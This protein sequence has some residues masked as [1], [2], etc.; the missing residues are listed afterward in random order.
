MDFVRNLE[1]K[2]WWINGFH[3]DG[4]TLERESIEENWRN[5]QSFPYIW[6]NSQIQGKLCPFPYKNL[7]VKVARDVSPYVPVMA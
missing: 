2:R 3:R 1:Q 7:Y 6:A 5:G 4:K